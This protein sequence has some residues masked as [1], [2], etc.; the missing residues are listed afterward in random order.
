[1]L[2]ATVFVAEHH[3]AKRGCAYAVV[4]L[5]WRVCVCV[6]ACVRVVLV[7]GRWRWCYVCVP[8]Q[9]TSA[10]H[11]SATA[12]SYIKS[13]Y[14]TA[15]AVQWPPLAVRHRPRLA[16]DLHRPEHSPSTLSSPTTLRSSVELVTL[17]LLLA[18]YDTALVMRAP[19]HFI[20]VA[21]LCDVNGVRPVNVR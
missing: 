12:T 16:D 13:Q 4:R 1:M 17:N 3:D 14:R 5:H 10:V 15:A 8:G 6:Y 11:S 2:S 9:W 7:W 21:W 19:Q 18:D 20:A